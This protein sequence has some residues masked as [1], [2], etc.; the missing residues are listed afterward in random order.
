M[1]QLKIK[2]LDGV[3]ASFGG[4]D[5]QI[6]EDAQDVAPT[7]RFALSTLRAALKCPALIL[8]TERVEDPDIAA[9]LDRQKATRLFY[10]PKVQAGAK[11]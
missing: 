4:L 6:A 1:R 7:G 11:Q 9:W 10:E 3:L 5:R 2:G 8:V